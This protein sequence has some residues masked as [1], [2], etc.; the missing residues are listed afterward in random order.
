MESHAGGEVLD[1]QI[2]HALEL[3]ARAP[4]S[5]I[6]TVLGVSDQTVA[7]R[8][9]RLRSE[10]G[11]RVVGVRCAAAE[12]PLD[13]WLLRVRCAPEGAPAIAEALAKRPDTAWIGLTSGGTEV[14][15]TANVRSRDDADDLLLGKLPR[16]PHILDIRAHQLLHRFYGGPSGWLH[17]SGALSPEQSA[18]LTPPPLPDHPGRAVITAEDEPLV[19]A[20]EADGRATYPALQKATGRSESAVK[21]RTAQLVASGALYVD[22]EFDCGHFG[23]G[24]PAMLSITA[25]PR[26]L[27]TVGEE[28]A[29][30]PEVAYAA[31]TTGAS[32]LV[33]VVITRDSG[34]LYRYL[35]ER[36]GQLEGVEHVESMPFLRR[37]KQLTYRPFRG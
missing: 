24:H 27:H 23:F 33:A 22:V 9:R 1:L 30:H 29:T 19:T 36:L 13:H 20:L 3:D 12:D 17:K 2:L 15:C 4:F 6:A 32:N 11:L 21:R 8:F 25:A 35:S 5:R 7:R 26:A 18:A 37:V 16:T 10:A 34:H 28:L 14:T 31:A